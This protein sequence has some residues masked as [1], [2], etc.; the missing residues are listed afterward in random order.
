[1]PLPEEAN[2]LTLAER[3]AVR[4]EG[5]RRYDAE[6]AQWQGRRDLR[7]EALSRLRAKNPAINF[8]PHTLAHLDET[9]VR[10]LDDLAQTYSYERPG[11]LGDD[12]R[13]AEYQLFRL[14]TEPLPPRPGKERLDYHL[15]TAVEQTLSDRGETYLPAGALPGEQLTEVEPGV[16][17]HTPGG[18]APAPGQGR[19]GPGPFEVNA[20]TDR[21]L[22]VANYVVKRV[23]QNRQAS[24]ATL[25]REQAVLT[26]QLSAAEPDIRLEEAAHIIAGRLHFEADPAKLPPDVAHGLAQYVNPAP[27]RNQWTPRVMHEGFAQ[28]MLRR[29][30]GT[31]HVG[32]P[33]QLAAGTYAENFVQ[34][35]GLGEALDRVGATYRQYL[36]QSPAERYAGTIGNR[37]PGAAGLTRGERASGALR[38][39]VDAGRRRVDNDLHD[40]ARMENH[41]AGQGNV[42]PAPGR[43]PMEVAQ[44]LRRAGEAFGA[45]WLGH[46]IPY[47]APDGSFRPASMGYE[48]A[49]KDIKPGDERLFNA[50]AKARDTVTEFQLEQQKRQAGQKLTGTVTREQ[51]DEAQRV[52][53]DLRVKDPARFQR[54]VDAHRN[55]VDA[56]NAGLRLLG[57]LGVMDPARAEEVILAHP[58]YTPR[59]RVFD[60]MTG[61]DFPATGGRGGTPGFLKSRGLSGEMTRP[62]LDTFR[63]RYARVARLAAKQLRDAPVRDMLRQP[64]MGKFGREMLE[65]RPDPNNPG[66]TLA[67]EPDDDLKPIWKTRE[68]GKTVRFM[69]GDGPLWD[70]LRG[71]PEVKSASVRVAEALAKIPVLNLAPKLIRLGAVAASPYWHLRDMSPTREPLQFTQ[72]SM[73]PASVGRVYK[74]YQHWP[75]VLANGQVRGGAEAAP[76]VELYERLAGDSQL[77]LNQGAEPLA[78]GANGFARF[79]RE[80]VRRLSYPEVV[81]RAVEMKNV[82]D[83]AGIDRGAVERWNQDGQL[84]PS[85]LMVRLQNAAGEVTHAYARKGVDVRAWE[86]VVPFFG[87]HVANTSKY[88][89]NWRQNPARMAGLLAGVL[90]SQTLYSG[91]KRDDQDYQEMPV[92]RR[93]DYQIAPTVALPRMRGPDAVLAGATDEAVRALTGTSAH[94]GRVAHDLAEQ[95][96]H[97]GP[98]PYATGARLLANRRTLSGGIPII[99]E[100]EAEGMTVGARLIDSRSLGFAEH[101]LTGGMASGLAEGVMRRDANRAL[102]PLYS[103]PYPHQSVTDYYDALHTAEVKETKRRQDLRRGLRVPAADPA[104]AR[105]KSAEKQM[106]YLSKQLRERPDQEGLIREQQIKLARRALGR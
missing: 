16:L 23:P 44:A 39:L 32:T 28:W 98:E 22:D 27:P 64:G 55:L 42:P 68:N 10:G 13:D 54:F 36:G 76:Y 57:Q 31:A 40:L 82:L 29:A 60:E 80:V 8:A 52:L 15:A 83:A 14:I 97:G 6:V 49:T 50:Y 69:I 41:S 81:P 70:Y 90:A 93:G 88:L 4:K 43:G 63:E 92:G 104:Y 24:A 3:A 2:D 1:M 79:L 30:E 67:A 86:K 105:L 102:N 47:V 7:A 18:A 56:A 38:R 37:M 71:E 100:R 96:V 46:G 85:D 17:F 84:P 94:P 51:H 106:A 26:T 5:Q 33:Q 91:W 77:Y 89:R 20:T 9:H 73:S 35:H 72:N 11:L 101:A 12:P 103:A 78:T 75:E 53:R 74:W 95:V 61:A 58:D 19:A 48:E 99:P 59:E 62:A 87:A 66:K 25:M 34:S 21:L 45:D 65:S